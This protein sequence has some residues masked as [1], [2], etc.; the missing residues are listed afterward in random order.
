MTLATLRAHIARD[1]AFWSARTTDEDYGDDNTHLDAWLWIERH[2]GVA[3]G[4]AQVQVRHSEHTGGD[5]KS[6]V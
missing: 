3:L 5:R 2:P 6:V 4:G 1:S